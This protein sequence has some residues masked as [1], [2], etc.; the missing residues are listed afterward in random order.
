MKVIQWSRWAWRFYLRNI[1]FYS[2][3][4]ILFTPELFHPGQ[5]TKI[6]Y[7]S[8]VVKTNK[9]TEYWKVIGNI[10]ILGL[11]HPP[12][13]WCYCLV[14][15]SYLTPGDGE[16]QG[17]LACRSPWG[18]KESDTTERLKN[19]SDSDPMDDRLPSSPVHGVSQARILEWVAISFSRG[20]SWP[21]DRTLIPCTGRRILYHWATGE[22]YHSLTLKYIKH[23]IANDQ[24]KAS[25]EVTT[26]FTSQRFS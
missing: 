22:A 26:L 19:M 14:A 4:Q 23:Y 16:G 7:A 25:A 8:S 13:C 18:R 12:D 5:V 11:G 17:S 6:P 1:P 24:L 10:G 3:F 15:K 9:V 2:N 21:G 20:S